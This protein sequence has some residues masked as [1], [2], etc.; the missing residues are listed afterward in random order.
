MSSLIALKNVSKRYKG[1]SKDAVRDVSFEIK[2]NEIFSL[3][4]VNGAGK[5]T[6]F[7]MIA[8]QHPV[9]SG[10][11]LWDGVSIYDNLLEYRKI[12]GLCPQKPSLDKKL[13][14]EKNLYFAGKFFGLSDEAIKLRI[15]QVS[16]MLGL[17]GYMNIKIDEL[18]GGYV[19]RCSIARSLM[20]SPKLLLLDEPTVGLDPHIRRQLWQLIENLKRDGVTIVLVTHYLDEAEFLSDRVCILDKG[21]IIAIDK[22]ENLKNSFAKNNLEDVFLELMSDTCALPK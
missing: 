19:Q 5:S 14:V 9:T 22:P 15:E 13:T 21:A 17:Q 12:I 4:G 16:Y 2:S 10:T 8:T 6:T 3:L 18:S 1:A 7:S 11:I 20:H